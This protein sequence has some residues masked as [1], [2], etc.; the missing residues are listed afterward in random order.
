MRW[1][2]LGTVASST[3]A[4]P[5]DPDPALELPPLDADDD[6]PAHVDEEAVPAH[7]ER[8]DLDDVAADDLDI[9]ET[10][11]AAEGVDDDAGD[12]TLDVGPDAAEIDAVD[13][14]GGTYEE[15][16]HDVEVDGISV[17]E[18]GD[19]EDGGVEGTGEDASDDVDEAALP[20]LDDDLEAADDASFAEELLVSAA[21]LAPWASD[22]RVQIEG[23]GATVP[24]RTVVAR[25]GRIAAAGEVLL[26]V[27]EGARSAKRI[28]FDDPV[29]AVALADDA[30][31]AGTARGELVHSADGG[32]TLAAHANLLSAGPHRSL[33]LHATPGRFWIR[34][35]GALS[36]VTFPEARPT[37]V[38]A[39]GVV[40][41][42]ANGPTLL[43]LVI[44][45]G[46]AFV[47]RARADDESRGEQRL[48]SAVATF[49]ERAGDGVELAACGDTRA[50]AI[51]SRDAVAVSRDGG[52][53]FVFARSAAPHCVHGIGF[54]G[55][56]A[57]ATLVLVAT[58]K[59]SAG[60]FLMAWDE[61]TGLARLAELPGLDATAS[62]GLAWDPSREAIWV[63]A[64]FGL[65][66]FGLPRRH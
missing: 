6:A 14:D 13:E 16:A 48:P 34:S 28:P 65:A 44:D 1:H 59:E 26:V 8:G 45:A 5:D 53:T 43:A 9:G 38:R 10:I 3:A 2:L 66:A 33:A 63:A 39:R 57:D 25:A 20:D 40:A 52:A 61:A 58:P 11:E 56:A 54:A 17:D 42:V 36:S 49:V 12:G 15:P 24:A 41:I 60:S 46:G 35:A 64:P 55:D 50:I 19:L 29:I 23:L 51:A 18:H 32:G 27:E 7:L 47:E 22:R 21:S 62:A 30:L 37:V 31:L 4:R